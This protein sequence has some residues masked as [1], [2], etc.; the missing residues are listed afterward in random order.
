MS[1]KTFLT[2]ATEPALDVAVDGAGR[3]DG[4]GRRTRAARG[5]VGARRPRGREGA[6]GAGPAD[7][8]P[9][10]GAGPL[11][12]HPRRAQ[13]AHAAGEAVA[14]GVEPARALP[15]RRVP[16]GRAPPP[17]LHPGRAV[18]APDAAPPVGGEVGPAGAAAAHR[19]LAFGAR[20]RLA[21]A[22]RARGAVQARAAVRG[23]VG[24]RRAPEAG[25]VARLAAR[26]TLSAARR[27][28]AALPALQG[29]VVEEEPAR[30]RETR[31]VSGQRAV[32]NL[33]LVPRA[34]RGARAARG[35]APGG[36]PARG[37]RLAHRVLGSRAGFSRAAARGTECTGLARLPSR[38][39]GVRLAGFAARVAPG[40]AL[41]AH[42]LPWRAS[43]ARRARP[44]PSRGERPRLARRAHRV[45]FQGALSL[46]VRPR[47]ASR[48]P[49]AHTSVSGRVM[50]FCACAA[51]GV[52]VR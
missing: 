10:T 42:V 47:G 48:A 52:G 23:G 30:A 39:V 13:R 11:H 19:V 29:G 8:V 37:A 40:R 20:R 41:P 46:P 36:E 14:R 43:S 9:A 18:R 1:R 5:A 27:A 6:L 7:G 4:L 51:A 2:S 31:R 15:A 22:G 32:R 50:T 34:A 24:P 38:R 28:G 35:F 16:L 26:L 44:A 49:S 17:R 25:R 45:G 21:P 12:E 3:Q 33:S